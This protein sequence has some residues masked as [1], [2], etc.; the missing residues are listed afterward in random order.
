MLLLFSSYSGIIHAQPLPDA[1]IGSSVRYGVEASLPN[2][3][4][5]WTVTG[6]NI[7]MGYNDSIDV[8][9]NYD[10]TNHTISVT[11]VSEFGCIGLTME[12]N[13]LVK[14]PIADIGDEA[15]VCRDDVYTFDGTTTYTTN[16]SYLWPDGS[17]EPTYS[18]GKEGYVW[19]KV[20]G[21]DMCA[22]YDSAYLTL[23][24]L[25]V[26]ILGPDTTLCGTDMIILD[27]G[28]FSSYEWS[29]GS[30]ASTIEV[31]GQRIVPEEF[32]VKVTDG[33]GCVGSDTIIFGVCDA[34][35]LFA[36]MPNTITPG[37]DGYN[38]EWIIPNIEKFPDAVLEIYDRWGR[39]VYRT[40]D[41]VNQPWKGQTMS[42]KDLP[43]D[44]YFFVLD[45]K[46]AHVKPVT[47]YVNIIR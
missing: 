7:V 27:P 8:K 20:T 10:R 6:G 26:I 12:A 3:T 23:N 29:T 11:E 35:L 46:V 21:T 43:M 31:D 30:I 47:G 5:I 38:N 44:A 36:N 2:S 32:W 9:W 25:P 13:V 17:T 1:C 28:F 15:E 45:I 39:L 18:T 40:N 34:A 19:V 16:I 42:G 22:D 41:I 37:D 4:F 33:N 14:G 24:P